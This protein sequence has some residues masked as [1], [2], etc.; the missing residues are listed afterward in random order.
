MT[1]LASDTAASITGIALPVDSGWTAHS[2]RSQQLAHEVRGRGTQED[3]HEDSRQW[4]FAENGT[5]AKDRGGVGGSGAAG[6]W[7]ARVGI[8]RG[9]SGPPPN[10]ARNRPGHRHPHPRPPSRP[11]CPPHPR[12]P[13]V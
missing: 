8:N 10:L 5:A 9:P 7:G 6:G 11:P 2:T 13:R 4:R 3:G 12:T 1:I